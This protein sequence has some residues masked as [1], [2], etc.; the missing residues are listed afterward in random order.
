[1]PYTNESTLMDDIYDYLFENT[2]NIGTN[3]LDEF[4]N[5]FVDASNAR[6]YL[7]GSELGDFIIKIERVA[8]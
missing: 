6:I 2:H 5:S 7:N 1:M 3:F 4:P 8:K